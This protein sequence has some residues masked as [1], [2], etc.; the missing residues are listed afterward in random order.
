M[1]LELDYTL[2][3]AQ[4]Q[5]NC[6][7][8]CRTCDHK[9]HLRIVD[10][11][12]PSTVFEDSILV[13]QETCPFGALGTSDWA[14]LVTL[15]AGRYML[16]YEVRLNNANGSSHYLNQARRTS[17][18]NCPAT[19]RP[20]PRSHSGRASGHHRRD[21][22]AGRLF[23]YCDAEVVSGNAT[24]HDEDGDG[25]ID[26]YLFGLGE[27]A[28]GF[29]SCEDIRVDTDTC[30]YDCNPDTRDFEAF[31]TDVAGAADR[32]YTQGLD[33]LEFDE[34]KDLSPTC[35]NFLS[36]LL[37]GPERCAGLVRLVRWKH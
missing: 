24:A 29:G 7:S 16:H 21:G 31:V 2:D 25:T 26:Y 14:D 1:T 37:S 11:D 12:G 15:D 22:H 33:Q 32:V 3:A 36:R 35:P 28:F 8:F 4:F 9:V 27:A 17:L 20:S 18:R 10:L 13:E 34:Y 6:L 30:K 19:S 5:S 23:D